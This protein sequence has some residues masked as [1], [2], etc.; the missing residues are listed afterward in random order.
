MASRRLMS[1][2]L[3]VAIVASA[4]AYTFDE[5]IVEY[6][7][8]SG[9]NEAVVVIDFGVDS[10]GFGYKWDSG[11]KYGKDLMDAVV[12]AGAMDY[13]EAGGFL[14]SISYGA[15][16]DVGLNGWPIDWWSYFI[17]GDGEHWADPG[18]GFATRELSSSSWDGWAHQTTDAWP[19][20]HVPTT[21]IPEPATIVLLGLGAVLLRQRE[22]RVKRGAK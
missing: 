21:P 3:V 15:Y 20:T 4:G 10:Y 2:V 9:G 16:S 7:A 8:G 5:I 22:P 1:V 14:S 17:S 6:W 19:P 13:A 18:E 12:A 11:T